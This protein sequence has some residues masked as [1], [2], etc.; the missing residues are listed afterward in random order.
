MIPPTAPII[1]ARKGD[2]ANGSAVIATKPPKAPFNIIITSVFPVTNL[3]TT[4]QAITPAHAAKF[5]LMKIVATAV[6]SSNDPIANWEPPLNPNHPIQRINTPKVAKGIEELA[7][8]AIGA[9]SPESVNLPKRGP[10]NIAPAKAAAAPAL[11]TSVEPAK[12][13][14]PAA[15]KWPP[16]HCHPIS[17]G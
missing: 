11:C 10:S 7:N 13:E 15:A 8:G 4:A 5:V 6:E 14:K 3:D 1:I 12:S 17:I 2:G 16:P 9:A